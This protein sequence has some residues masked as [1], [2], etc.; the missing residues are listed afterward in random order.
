[1]QG[2]VAHPRRD[3][4]RH[5]EGG[6]EEE[7]DEEG[8]HGLR[9]GARQPRAAQQRIDALEDE[10]AAAAHTVEAA[11]G[12][13]QSASSASSAEAKTATSLADC[14]DDRSTQQR[15]HGQGGAHLACTA[16]LHHPAAGGPAHRLS[17]SRAPT[18]WRPRMRCGQKACAMSVP[19]KKQAGKL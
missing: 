6:Q 7:E 9:F 15:A 3:V 17:N 19:M 2:A 14:D 13:S 12:G 1:M 10:A 8:A 4:L 5:E 18:P 11:G 16:R